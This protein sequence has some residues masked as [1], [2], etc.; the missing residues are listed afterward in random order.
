[1]N[2]AQL[3][4]ILIALAGLFSLAGAYFN[5]DWYMNNSR[6][7][8]L[9]RFIGRR[10]ARVFYAALGLALVVAGIMTAF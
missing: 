5:W 7:R 9:V 3:T 8:L 10:G 1:M 4:G 6:A 2:E